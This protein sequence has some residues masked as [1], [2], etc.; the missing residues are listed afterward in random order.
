MEIAETKHYS[1]K[2]GSMAKGCRLCVKGLKSVLFVTGLCPKHCFYC[3][4]S[5]KKRGR[6]IVYINEMPDAGIKEII[7][8]IKLCG[9]KG[10]GIT[11]GD[12]LAR[13]E[14]VI[15]YIKALKKRFGKK[16]HIH[17][18]TPLN[19]VDGKKL[20]KLYDA[21]LD[22]IRIHPDLNSKKEWEKIGLALNY[23][24]RVG[25]E[26][27]AVPGLKRE[28]IEII[29]YLSGKIDFLNINE[30]E[31]SDS[32]ANSLVEKGFMPKN[33][34]SYGV[35]GSEELGLGLLEY[36]AK[37][38]IKLN[39]HYCTTTLKDK[40]QL[41]KRIKRRAANIKKDY[42]ILTKDGMLKRGAIYLSSFCPGFGYNK[43]IEKLGRNEKS[44]ILKRLNKIKKELAAKYTI[45]KKLIEIDKQRLRI[46]TSTKIIKKIKNKSIKRAVVEEYP[47]YDSMIVELEFL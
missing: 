2:I 30:L 13:I 43:K 17:L 28:T 31:V 47:T 12:P 14:R 29:N 45:P 15:K 1:W 9:S 34:T 23:K 33:E 24:W 25:V 26:I 10:I 20:K 6:D 44:M 37:N 38:R 5:D 7:K 27:P 19:L 21:G 8:E 11:G 39:A 18:Y 46:L 3:P 32:N 41:A 40:I 16:F 36:I 42:D 4:I 35:K 22:E